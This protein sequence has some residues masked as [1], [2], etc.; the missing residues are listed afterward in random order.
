MSMTIRTLAAVAAIGVAGGAGAAQLDF[1]SVG[2]GNKG[3]QIVLPDATVDLISGS[4]LNVGDFIPNTVCAIAAGCNG[5]F[6]I[7]W[8]MI[9]RGV[10]FEYGFG[11]PGDSA[12]ITGYDAGGN[13]VGV[14]NL[15]LTNGTSFEDLSAFG[16]V[17]RIVFDTSASTGA[18]YAYGNINYAPVP[19]PA[20]LPLLVAALAGL[21]LMRRRAG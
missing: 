12:V 3:S 19:L 8:N 9:V 21:G 6:E 10:D 20:A 17:K 2:A 18:G 16:A 15:T 13:L 7:T 1:T 11:N 5:I 4:H 14:R